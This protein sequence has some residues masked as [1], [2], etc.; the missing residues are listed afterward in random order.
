LADNSLSQDP[1]YAQIIL[2][3]CKIFFMCI[4]VS[5][6]LVNLNALDRRLPVPHAATENLA[7]DWPL[8]ESAWN[9]TQSEPRNTGWGYSNSW[10]DEQ[11]SP[12]EA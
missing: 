7:L 9:P 11:A 1:N 3:I 2:L 8:R 5:L 12:V 10:A 4:Q 6:D